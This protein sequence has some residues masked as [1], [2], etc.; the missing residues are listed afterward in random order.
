MLAV[1]LVMASCTEKSE[2]SAAKAP[3]AP[4]AT[5]EVA[6]SPRS[7]DAAIAA[8]IDPKRIDG[9]PVGLAF[10]DDGGLALAT[11]TEVAV[12]GASGISGRVPLKGRS[13][14]LE[15]GQGIVLEGRSEVA[16]LET[17]SL[18]ELYSGPG[19]VLTRPSQAIAT[20]GS[21]TSVLVQHAG[22]LARFTLPPGKS[23]RVDT[24]E[25]TASGKHAV[26]TWSIED[27]MDADAAVFDVA[28]ARMIGHARPMPAFSVAPTASLVGDLQVAI[29][30]NEVLVIDL[31]SAAIVRR[32]KVACPKDSFLGNP[33]SAPGSD[34]VLVTCGA[35]GI[36]LDAKTLAPRRRYPRI[37]PGCDN[38]ELLPGHFDQ[39]KNELVLEGCGGIAR[40][41][42]ATGKYRCSDEIGLAGAEYDVAPSPNGSGRRAPPGREN[43]PHCTKDDDAM[44]MGIGTSGTYAITYGEPS[45]IV[46]AGGRIELEPAASQFAIARDEKRIAY[47]VKGRVIVR[48]LPAGA[49]IQEIATR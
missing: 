46:H 6:P 38:G 8:T 27:T 7:E 19:Y 22:K 32:A 48:S 35:D 44:N 12:A 16:L 15:G 17:P 33:T 2:R 39:A 18:R 3:I 49:I 10:L 21:A 5:V 24:I 42:L 11:D 26:V 31:A 29:D 34:V 30:K 23:K 43:L 4:P 47:A 41:E 9:D 28:T 20:T 40:M 13:A 37:M 36:G 25:I 14:R 45:A 1:T